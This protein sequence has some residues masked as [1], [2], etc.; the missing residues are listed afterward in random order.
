MIDY[1]VMNKQLTSSSSTIDF[2]VPPSS[3]Q[4]CVFVQDSG[5]GTSTKIPLSR[6]KSRQYSPAGSLQYLN[7]FGPWTRTFDEKLKNLQITFSGQTKPQ[8]NI[9]NTQNF[10][11]QD[12]TS[13]TMLQRYLMTNQMA[14]R[15]DQ[16]QYYDFV[17]MGPYYLFDYTRD[18]KMLGTYVSCKLSFNGNL[19]TVG[20]VANDTGSNINL[21]V[22]AIYKRDV[23]ISYSEFGNVISVVTAMQ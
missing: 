18:A 8:T 14:G 19:P 21:Y 7:Q 22:C 13:N 15:Y 1:I 17:N 20:S 9:E 2:T 16:E 11:V 6:F 3:N 12:A 5:A 4:L 10:S 23:A